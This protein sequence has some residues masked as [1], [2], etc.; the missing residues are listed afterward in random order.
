MSRP[1]PITEAAEEHPEVS[2]ISVAELVAAT[3]GDEKNKELQCLDV[4]TDEEYN[5]G[6]VVGAMNVPSEQLLGE[7]V[8]E[9]VAE[10][11]LSKFHAAGTKTVVVYCMYGQGRSPTIANTLAALAKASGL[12]LEIALLEGGF[13]AF[14][15]AV[16]SKEED[17]IGDVP[18]LVQNVKPVKWRRTSTH[19]LVNADAV[20][21]V[22]QLIS[23]EKEKDGVVS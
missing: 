14:I 1:P 8:Q 17:A 10:E 5:S 19:G 12:S 2:K 16:H 7:G 22:E 3:E 11:L 6:H 9:S 13:H 21:S 20:A 15:N 18:G 23:E 4:R